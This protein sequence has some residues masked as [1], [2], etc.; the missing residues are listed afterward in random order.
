MEAPLAEIKPNIKK[1]FIRNI[2][3]VGGI[4]FLVIIVLLCLNSVVGL[5]IFLDVIGVLGIVISPLAVLAYFI[6]FVLF[7]TA[8][9][10]ILNYVTLG[11]IGYTL[12][13]DKMVYSESF[14]IVHIS[15]KVIPYANITKI[16][17]EKK[18]F[19]N[20]AKII[21][22]LTGMKQD[23]V[24]LN[25]IDEAEEVVSKLQ[26]LVRE[27]RAKYYAKY[28]QEYRYQNIMEQV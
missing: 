18:P 8:L 27:Y 24:T 13:Q 11:K 9:S 12:Y 22:D 26:E 7:F 19:L 21:L 4:V 2:L 28:S 16:S 14:F 23:K 5:S 15:D 1:A 10:L 20:T 3:I 17:Y 25:F 6:F